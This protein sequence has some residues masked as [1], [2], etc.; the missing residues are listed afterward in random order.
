MFDAEPSNDMLNAYVNA[1]VLYVDANKSDNRN[2]D[3]GLDFNRNV[4]AAPM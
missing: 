1:D 3:L 4:L 2:V